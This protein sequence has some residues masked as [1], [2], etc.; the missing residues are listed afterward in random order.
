LVERVDSF[1]GL[2][3]SMYCGDGGVVIARS[4]DELLRR[5]GNAARHAKCSKSA[6]KDR[7]GNLSA[8]HGTVKECES[9][10]K[11][12]ASAGF[13]ELMLIFPGWER[14]DYSNMVTFAENFIG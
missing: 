7:L 13:E 11:A 6:M 1:G 10:E 14:G 9:K 12:L 2:K 4:E 5:I 8:L 3:K